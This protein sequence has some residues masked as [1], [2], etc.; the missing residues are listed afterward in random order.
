MY[1]AI[2]EFCFTILKKLYICFFK[3]GP[4]IC[5]PFVFKGPRETANPSLPSYWP[6][7]QPVTSSNPT[8]G[9]PCA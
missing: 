6:W 2:C 5:E 4:I 1:F 3:S 9:K 8:N 7:S